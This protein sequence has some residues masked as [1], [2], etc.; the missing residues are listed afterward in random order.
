MIDCFS[1]NLHVSVQP[2]ELPMLTGIT[3]K[4]KL[5]CTEKRHSARTPPNLQSALKC[6]VDQNLMEISDMSYPHFPER[7]PSFLMP[8]VVTKEAC[9]IGVCMHEDSQPPCEIGS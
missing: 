7:V 8:A 4:Q 1:D 5:L 9:W 3:Q 2:S 6:K